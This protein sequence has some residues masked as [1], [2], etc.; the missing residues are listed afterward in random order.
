MAFNPFATFQKNKRFWM[1]VILGVCMVAFIL[2]DQLLRQFGQGTGGRS[3]ATIVTIGGSNV[4]SSDLYDLKIQR[5]LAN[6]FMQTCADIA[7]KN[8]SRTLF[9]GNKKLGAD[10]EIDKR[11]QEE[12]VQ[13]E[14]MQMSL[15][16]RKSKQ[17]Y[18]ETGVKFDDLAEFKLWQLQADRMGVRLD[19]EHVQFLF[20]M[21]F[22]QYLAPGDI[23]A[24]ELSLRGNFSHVWSKEYIRAAIREEFRVKIAQYAVM[25]AQP[26]SYL[27]RQ[28]KDEEGMQLKFSD[29][30]MPDQIRAPMTLAQLY[31]YFKSQRSEFD[32]TL[33]P[34]SVKQFAE[35]IKAEPNALQMQTYFDARKDKP[36]DP[37]SDIDGLERP[38]LLKVEYIIADP[39]APGYHNVAK[40]LGTLNTVSPIGYDPTS[41]PL[42]TA[43]RYLAVHEKKMIDLQNQY[44]TLNPSRFETDTTKLSWSGSSSSIAARL[45][46][47]HPEAAASAA[48]AAVLDPTGA[49]GNYLY[50]GATKHPDQ[51]AAAEQAELKRRSPVFATLVG[52]SLSLNPLDIAGPV[53]AMDLQPFQPG[54]PFY[55]T[56]N[57]PLPVEAVQHEISDM[58]TRR[59]AEEWAQANIRKMKKALDTA[60]GDPEKFKRELNRN[61]KELNLT[62]GPPDEKKSAY[63]SRYSVNTAPELEP[64]RDAYLKYMDM[65]NL[66]EGRDVTPERILKANDFAKVFF[67][68]TESFSAS[69]P[70]RAMPWP[71]EVKPN[72]APVFKADR[73]PRLI[74]RSNVNPEEFRRFQQHMMG[75]DPTKEA[76]KFELFN[77]A[78]K[79]ILFWRTGDLPAI[80]IG[81]YAKI[82]KDM[83]KAAT[84]LAALD[85]EIKTHAKNA[86]KISELYA[87]RAE[88]LKT[89]ADLKD[90]QDRIIQGWKLEQAREKEVLPRAKEVALEVMK[91]PDN[92]LT[93]I[94]QREKLKTDFVPLRNV[95]L[96]HAE[97]ISQSTTDYFPYPLPKD[98]IDYPRDDTAQHIVNLYHLK[99]PIKVGNDPLDALNKELFEMASKDKNPAGK[100]VQVL[101][102]KPRTVYYV[103]SVSKLPALDRKQLRDAF[104]NAPFQQ[105]HDLFLQRAQENF[106]RQYRVEYVNNLKTLIGYNVVD[107]AARKQFD[108]RGG[109]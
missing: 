99:E 60:I 73:D 105:E 79:P 77:T 16:Y 94:A 53:L 2:G 32:V 69:S 107:D 58:L 28:K 98:S 54:L 36:M 31:E 35:N 86:L 27:T 61:L 109:D 30:A 106:A 85:A 14:R 20:Q 103:A 97:R 12:L 71:P 29:P 84:E 45:S 1:A 66:F 88:V 24:A 46:K 43:S 26:F 9:E 19:A 22:Y 83:K 4:S 17:R 100:F 5:N 41:S 56:K 38:P 8:M 90:I 102:N 15:A 62:Y 7:Y 89:E 51:L 64:L 55:F 76:P 101:T 67:D 72:N 40:L 47:Q 104:L 57:P 48:A 91:D 68:P 87:K 11:K 13:L 92:P 50:W 49:L 78:A 18:F 82:E 96:M 3:G 42:V 70:Y 59:V 74:N 37:S 93:Y 25:G 95:N 33:I 44:E 65:I 39:S 63:Y 75:Q 23:G 52:S 10:K 108:D 81:D 6:Q 80:R 34:L 21:E